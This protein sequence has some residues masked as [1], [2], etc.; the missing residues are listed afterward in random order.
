MQTFGKYV[1]SS[2]G[3]KHLMGLTGI[4]LYFFLFVHLVGNVGMLSGP[5]Y[6]NKYG[7][8][9]LHTLA[10]VVYPIELSLLAGFLIHVA[11]GFKLT[12]ENRAARPS[13]YAVTASKRGSMP[14]S[15]FMAITGSW[16]L[17]F[18]ITHVSYFRFGAG[19]TIPNVVYQGIATSMAWPW[20][21]FPNPGSPPFMFFLFS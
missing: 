15:R 1:L 9:M 2:I 18:V 20:T 19:S 12:L 7:H 14:L 21:P 5:E 4:Y 17:L 16:M 6:F 13:R 8:L 3:R 10:K 11:L